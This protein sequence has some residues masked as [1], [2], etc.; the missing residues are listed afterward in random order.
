MFSIDK[1]MMVL[2]LIIKYLANDLNILKNIL[3]E[4]TDMLKIIAHDMVYERIN[5]PS[6]L[7]EQEG[8]NY[9]KGCLQR[10]N[11]YFFQG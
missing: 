11:P 8:T 9:L 6:L 10:N 3:Y 2:L 5:Q 4:L 1:S 7:D